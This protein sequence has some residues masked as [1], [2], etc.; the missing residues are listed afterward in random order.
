MASESS[1]RKPRRTRPV[2]GLSGSVMAVSEVLPH[3]LPREVMN[4]EH[5]CAQP[6]AEALGEIDRTPEEE[7]SDPVPGLRAREARRKKENEASYIVYADTTR[8]GEEPAARVVGT[9]WMPSIRPRPE[10]PWH[11]RQ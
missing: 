11:L 9:A 3:L 1:G 4:R 2:C 6:D 8:A 10:A 5:P 7:L